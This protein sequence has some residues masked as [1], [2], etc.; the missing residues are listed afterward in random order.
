MLLCAPP[1][2]GLLGKEESYPLAKKA[3][4]PTG[5]QGS[6]HAGAEEGPGLRIPPA[7]FPLSSPH[8]R[9]IPS[10]R[11]LLSS[12]SSALGSIGGRLTALHLA[13]E[14]ECHSGMKVA[15]VI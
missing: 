6:V 12:A 11:L 13:L 9:Q 8:S 3:G 4:T 1:S 15:F 2:L 5:Q 14:I 10:G 7:P